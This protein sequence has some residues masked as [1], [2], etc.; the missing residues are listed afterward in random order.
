MH[1]VALSA[2]GLLREFAEAGMI[3]VA[4]HHLAMS[5]ARHFDT[6]DE[7]VLAFALAARE[8][9]QGSVYVPLR[10]ASELAPLSEI[11]DGQDV[12][13]VELRW[14]EPESWIEAVAGSRL[15]GEGRAFMLD[16][17][18][19]YLARFWRTEQQVR[20]ALLE[21]KQLP[22]VQA[23]PE[24]A[25]PP[26][27]KPD[28]QQ[29]QAVSAALT[30]MTS[31]IT[32]GPGTGKTTTVVRILNAL[33]AHTPVA[34]ALA[35]PT[36]R[37]AR[38]LEDSVDGRLAKGAVTELFAGTLHKL[39]GLRV[40][41]T[42]GKFHRDNPLPYDVVVLDETSMVS[43]EHM[44]ALLDALAP[45]TRLI[46]VGDPH[47]LRSVEAGAVLA[48]V[49]E[50]PALTQPGSVV[51]L[52]TN[53]RSN[54]EINALAAAIDVGAIDEAVSIIEEASTIEFIDYEGRG[55]ERLPSLAADLV[56]QS[57]RLLSAARSGDVKAALDALGHHRI[58]CA[59]R[60]GAFGVQEWAKVAR[61]VIAARHTDYGGEEPYVGQPLLITRNTEPF[62]NGDVGVVVNVGGHLRAAIDQ[63]GGSEPVIVSPALLDDAADLH[64]MTIHKSQGG[65]YETVSVVLPPVGSPLATRE[66][67]YTAVTRAKTKLRLYGS[68]EALRTAIATP[69]RRA[70]GL[71]SS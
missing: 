10:A 54:S 6:P 56:E 41:A 59:H 62:S 34:V 7:V 51:R 27:T 47:Q 48:D 29:E 19:L 35:A 11:D 24:G 33:G 58:L 37:A 3:S 53:R 21:R 45:T 38:Q 55:A 28:E 23:V 1:E 67:L 69:V 15:V 40:R 12:E 32:G 16:D 2:S 44:A 61:S 5:L 4:D 8:L 63:G 42:T 46:L 26:G 71:A 43:L 17:D 36:G 14:P 70:S 13:P 68:E 50:N 22:T 39:L 52:G 20:S 30:H 25:L 18:R 57:D 31:V 64:A 9:R 49:V 66:L 65:Q 60:V